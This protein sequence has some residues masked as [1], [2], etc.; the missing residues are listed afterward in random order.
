MY[1]EKGFHN[2]TL[3]IEDPKMAEYLQ[4]LGF[5]LKLYTP[6]A[7][8]NGDVAEPFYVMSMDIKDQYFPRV[9]DAIDI[10]H[11]RGHHLTPST[12]GYLDDKKIVGIDISFH[13][14]KSSNPRAVWTYPQID[15]VIFKY[16]GNKNYTSSFAEAYK[17]IQFNDSGAGDGMYEPDQFDSVDSYEEY[18]R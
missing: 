10:E 9:C 6:R 13:G 5:N 18:Y 3:K 16:E 4:G 8:R 12:I 15:E 14:W 11:R 2:F 7:D 1:N 17:D